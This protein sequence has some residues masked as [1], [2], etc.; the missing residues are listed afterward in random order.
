[1]NVAKKKHVPY[2]HL[3]ERK[4]GLIKQFILLLQGLLLIL[5]T[6]MAQATIDQTTVQELLAENRTA[7]D[8]FGWIV[9]V[10]GDTAVIGA[11][12]ASPSG[13]TNAGAAYVFT[14]SNGLWTQQTKLTAGN[15][16]THGGFGYSVSVDADTAVVGTFWLPP[17]TSFLYQ[18][19][20]CLWQP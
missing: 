18:Y 4:H 2:A 15:K 9:S 3:H 13:L 8:L 10:S 19:G 7:N 14:Y 6:G 11:N 5:V 16:A 20:L 12:G 1:M 17:G